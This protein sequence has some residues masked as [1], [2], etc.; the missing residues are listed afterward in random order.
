[1]SRLS[2][3]YYPLPG[4][5]HGSNP[6]TALLNLSEAHEGGFIDYGQAN[7]IT[8][9]CKT[10]WSDPRVET[11][12]QA[13]ENLG[14]TQIRDVGYWGSWAM[15]TIKG[16]GVL[17]EAFHNPV[18]DPPHNGWCRMHSLASTQ[19]QPQFPSAWS[20]PY[21]PATSVRTAL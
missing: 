10:P 16:Q 5:S 20:F 3:S 8:Y 2:G 13:L 14:S 21:V 15:I 4:C 11:S 9:E 1:L 12:Y 19:V 7:P 17:T 6:R 18:Y